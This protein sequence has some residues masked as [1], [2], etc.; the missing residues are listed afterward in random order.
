MSFPASRS[1]YFSIPDILAK[2]ERVPCVFNKNVHF[3]GSLDP[4]IDSAVL[5]QGTNLELP[6]WLVSSL[7]DANVLR[8]ELPKPF[9]E[10]YRDILKAGPSVV[11]L[12]KLCKYY[13]EF[14]KLIAQLPH[15]ESTE[16][17]ESL[18]QTFIERHRQLTDWAQNL[19]VDCGVTDKLD[20]YEKGLLERGK[21]AS[22]DL[23]DWLAHGVKKITTAQLVSNHKK[24]K[25]ITLRPN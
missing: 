10:N 17:K 16:L 25:L 19:E 2:Q 5:P 24:R 8:V 9:R 22:N 14:G 1:H 11:D 4:S 20:A 13:L 18:I 23:K 7:L 6:Y 21:A 3:L 12:F 15:R